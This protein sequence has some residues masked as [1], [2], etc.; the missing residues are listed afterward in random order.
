M[1]ASSS[2]VD[3]EDWVAPQAFQPRQAAEDI[4]VIEETAEQGDDSIPD[5]DDL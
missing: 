3:E 4:P 1:D 2:G 5:I